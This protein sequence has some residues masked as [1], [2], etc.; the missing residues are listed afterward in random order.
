MSRIFLTG[1]T[2]M[3]GAHLLLDLTRNGTNVCVLKRRSSDLQW[4][5]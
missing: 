2:G 1:G 3:L 4:V 5:R